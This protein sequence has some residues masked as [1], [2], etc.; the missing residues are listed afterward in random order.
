MLSIF[1]YLSIQ[2]VKNGFFAYFVSWVLLQMFGVN[3]LSFSMN[4]Q[5]TMAIIYRE[6]PWKKEKSFSPAFG[7]KGSHTFILHWAQKLYSQPWLFST[8]YNI[9]LLF[10]YLYVNHIMC[11]LHLAFSLNFLYQ[12]FICVKSCN[13]SSVQI[14]VLWIYLDISLGA[15][16]QG[17]F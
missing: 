3:I 6:R 13:S 4:C 11:I 5:D 1:L 16:V 15:P 8:I 2:W 14:M 9:L 12:G 7:T 10:L 17:Y